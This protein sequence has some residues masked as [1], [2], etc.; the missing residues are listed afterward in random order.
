MKFLFVALALMFAAPVFAQTAAGHSTAMTPTP[1]DRAK[2][3]LTLI[4]DQNYADAY[5]QMGAVARGKVS[6]QDFAAKIGGARTPFGAMSSRTLKDVNATKTLPGMRDGQYTIV[7]Y[8]SAFAHMAAS[9]ESVTLESE[10]GAW[11]V[12]GYHIN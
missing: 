6:E 9:I 1:D 10:N 7:R 3:W 11:S 4:D 8:D 5:K 12:V 2:Q